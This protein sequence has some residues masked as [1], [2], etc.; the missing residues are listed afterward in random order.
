M[1]PNRLTSDELLG[2]LEIPLNEICSYTGILHSKKNLCYSLRPR[3]SDPP[4]LY[5]GEVFLCFT[6]FGLKN[7]LLD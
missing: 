2:K 4:H 6:Y 3:D 5:C 7:Q 1:H